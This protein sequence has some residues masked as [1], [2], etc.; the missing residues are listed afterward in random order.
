MPGYD[1]TGPKGKGPLTGRGMGFCAITEEEYKK[2]KEEQS[3]EYPE[4]YEEFVNGRGRG[5]G[6]RRGCGMG[7][8]HRHGWRGGRRKE[9]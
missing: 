7:W 8:R 5:W 2:L 9:E 6:R 4:T 3:K 1:G